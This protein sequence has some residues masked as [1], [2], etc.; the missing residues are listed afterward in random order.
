MKTNKET[1]SKKL[2]LLDILFT[3]YLK[4]CESIL[5]IGSKNDLNKKSEEYTDGNGY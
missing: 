2:D 3:E 4:S 5:E 1:I